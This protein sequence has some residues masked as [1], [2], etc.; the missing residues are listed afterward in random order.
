MNCG[1]CFSNQIRP[2]CWIYFSISQANL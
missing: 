1:V 2:S